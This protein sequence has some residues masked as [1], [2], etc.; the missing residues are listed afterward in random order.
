MIRYP[1][2]KLP[3]LFLYG[4]ENSGKSI[5]HESIALL[6]T[7]GCVPADR[8]LTSTSDFNGELANCVLAI[9]EEKD[10]SK[11]KGALAKIKDW[12]TSLTIS[13]RRMQTDSYTQP[14]TTHWVQCANKRENCPI[15]PGDTRIT[16]IHVPDLL[17]DQEIPKDKLIELLKEE[18][19]HFMYSLMNVELPEPSG[20]LRIPIVETVGKK[21]A[22][23]LNSSSFPWA[24]QWIDIVDPA[25]RPLPDADAMHKKYRADTGKSETVVQFGRLLTQWAKEKECVIK[26][27]NGP[28][29]DGVRTRCWYGGIQ[30]R[31][32]PLVTRKGVQA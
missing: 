12:V 24:D 31:T 9:V 30:V 15:F 29:V 27:D 14:N 5:F 8:A 32:V 7:K 28:I 1:F 6:M 26:S 4:P 2:K 25:T 19:P 23:S 22:Q 21:N 17:E 16:A 10:I 20:R 13:I 18:A 11:S 3:Y